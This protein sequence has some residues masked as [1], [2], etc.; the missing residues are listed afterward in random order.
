MQA[1]SEGEKVL[2]QVF[3]Q[4]PSFLGGGYNAVVKVSNY[5]FAFKRPTKKNP[6]PRSLIGP[7]IPENSSRNSWENKTAHHC[8]LSVECVGLVDEGRFQ[9]SSSQAVAVHSSSVTV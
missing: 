9:C 4:Y 7:L 5:E 8:C 6:P 2:L 1:V 3:G